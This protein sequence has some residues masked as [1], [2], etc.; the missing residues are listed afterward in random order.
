MITTK[1]MAILFQL[2]FPVFLF[3]PES[4]HSFTLLNY[5]GFLPT[6]AF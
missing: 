6:G 3:K 4:S 5:L 1:N 2:W